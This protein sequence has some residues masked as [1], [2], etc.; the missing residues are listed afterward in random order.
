[1]RTTDWLPKFLAQRTIQ[2]GCLS[3]LECTWPLVY[4][5]CSSSRLFSFLPP[6]CTSGLTPG[7]HLTHCTPLFSCLTPL[8]HFPSCELLDE[9]WTHPG[10]PTTQEHTVSE[11]I[12]LTYPSS[13][14]FRSWH[15]FWVWHLSWSMEDSPSRKQCHQ[16]HQQ[17]HI[18]AKLLW[19]QQIPLW[20]WVRASHWEV[21]DKLISWA[22]H[23]SQLCL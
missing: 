15:Y 3:C 2:G 12:L 7:W 16:P 9:F 4:P 8:S 19:V 6:E 14:S 10:I 18:D 22:S 1:M 11:Y 5:R 23:I 13:M 17:V 21:T 20:L